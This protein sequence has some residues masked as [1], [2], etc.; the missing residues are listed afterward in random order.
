MA[1]SGGRAR[2]RPRASKPTG[3]DGNRAGDGVA[4]EVE[5]SRPVC[6]VGFCPICLAVT[7][8]GD[9]RPELMEHLLLAGREMLLAVRSVIDARL[10]GQ[11]EG[12]TRLE[13]LTI[14]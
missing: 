8:L 10:E 13:H 7:T 1:E 4:V 3:T 9:L 14:E 12:R 2:A 5:R 6:S 11:E